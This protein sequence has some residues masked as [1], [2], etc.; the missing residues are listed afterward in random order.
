MAPSAVLA[1]LSSGRLMYAKAPDAPRPIASLTKVMTALLVLEAGDLDAEVTIP[2]AAVFRPHDYGASTTAGLEEGERLTV[3]DL[4]YA[5]MLGSANDAAVAL[6][7][8]ESGSTEAF[9]DAMNAKAEEL[10]MDASRFLSPN[11]LDD[12]GRSTARDLVTLTRFAYDTPGFSRIVDTKRRT[13]PGPDETTRTIQ[14]RNVL[15][16]LYPGAIGA[17]TGYTAAAGYCLDAA[18][19]RSGRRRVAIVLGTPTDA[20]SDAA[21]LLNYGF[22]AFESHT[23]V[24]LGEPLGQA[25]IRG[26]SIPVVAGGTIDGLVPKDA[27]AGARRSV[28]IAPSAAF[29]TAPGQ[30]VGILRVTIPGLTVGTVPIL[31]D[32]LPTPTPV[33]DAP[34]WVRAADTIGRAVAEAVG[35]LMP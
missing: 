27:V 13:I 5:M 4:L 30:A 11:G 25:A 16:W 26:G 17:K 7:I 8:H 35:G 14:N 20:F 32:D 24:R 34:W 3:R 28:R 1:D 31:A 19:T 23:F 21:A 29:P 12:R 22:G 10:G 33:D 15:L 6:A 2:A 9:V 18:A